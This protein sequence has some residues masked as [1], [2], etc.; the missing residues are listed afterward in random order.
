M[1]HVGP[2]PGPIP[3]VRQPWNL[4]TTRQIRRALAYIVILGHPDPETQNRFYISASPP[5]G[6]SRAAQTHPNNKGRIRSKFQA[7]ARDQGC[8]YAIVNIVE[9]RWT[10]SRRDGTSIHSLNTGHEVGYE[11]Y[12]GIILIGTRYEDEELPALSAQ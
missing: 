10:V 11:G 2:I 3:V 9:Y 8:Y 6:V 1:G 7:S 12:W 4:I 5:F